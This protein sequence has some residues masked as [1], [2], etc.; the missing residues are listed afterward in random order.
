MR[1][2][3]FSDGQLNL[4]DR[5]Q[6]LKKI[7][8]H[9]DKG[10]I[11]EAFKTFYMTQEIQ[12]LFINKNTNPFRRYLL[13][14]SEIKKDFSS[15]LEEGLRFMLRKHSVSQDIIDSYFS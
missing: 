9:F 5:I 10:K 6:N 11:R 2:E 14:H 7:K 13:Q 8:I 1:L 4:F 3:E 12:N 15:L